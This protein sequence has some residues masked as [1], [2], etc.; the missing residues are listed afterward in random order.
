MLTPWLQPLLRCRILGEFCLVVF[1][2]YMHLGYVCSCLTITVGSHGKLTLL[3]VIHPA[4]RDVD[5]SILLCSIICYTF[6]WFKSKPF[7][8]SVKDI[9]PSNIVKTSVLKNYFKEY[10]DTCTH[11]A[12]QSWSSSLLVGF[13]VAMQLN[14]PVIL[15]LLRPRE[16]E[17]WRSIVMSAS[18]CV[19]VCPRAYSLNHTRDLCQIFC[20]CLSPWLG[21]PRAG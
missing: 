8:A 5:S 7:D 4:D 19:S 6:N 13:F 17:R 20:A 12:T 21:P 2:V 9:L 11:R 18:V 15:L 1:L 10:T 16:R 14:L 3:V